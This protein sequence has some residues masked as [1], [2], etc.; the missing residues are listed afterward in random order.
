MELGK[1]LD[2]LDY[3]FIMK[4]IEGYKC[5]NSQMKGYTGEVLNKEFQ[6]SFFPSMVAHG[7]ILVHQPRRSQTC[8][9]WVFMEDSL[10]RLD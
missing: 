5:I 6:R 4:D 10:H 1:P 8:S 3:W 2:S 7:S 9:W